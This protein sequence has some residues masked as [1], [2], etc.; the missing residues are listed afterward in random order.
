MSRIAKVKFKDGTVF[1]TEKSGEG[2]IVETETSHKIRSEPHADFRNALDELV[3]HARFILEWPSSLYPDRVRISS[4]SWSMSDDTGVEGAVMTGLVNLDETDSPFSFNTPHLPFDQYNPGGVAKTMPAD[5]I[6]ALEE[7]RTEVREYLKGKRAQG[8][9]FSEDAK[10]K[11]AN[12]VAA[13][14]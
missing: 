11:A 8:D 13:T 7:F 4:V 14:H 5:A 10:S 12:D 3:Q 9:L 2:S 6:E 1:V